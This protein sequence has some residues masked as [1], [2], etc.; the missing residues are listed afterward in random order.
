MALKQPG[1]L[2]VI[3]LTMLCAGCRQLSNQ[4][5]SQESELIIFAAA[6][7][8]DAFTEIARQFE[9]DHPG[10]KVIINFA[11]S[12]QLAHQ[13][14]QG[15]PADVFASANHRQMEA[16]IGFGRVNEEKVEIFAGNRLVIA[17]PSSN[18]ADIRT[19]AG[20]STPGLKLLLAAPEVPAGAYTLILLDN[21]ESD[22]A[23]GPAFRNDVLRNVVSY[24]ENVRAVLS[25]VMLGEA[26][27]GIVYMSDVAG[28]NEDEVG[29][30]EIPDHLNPLATYPIA[31]INNS[32]QPELGKVFIDFLLSSRGQRLISDYGFSAGVPSS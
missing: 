5:S 24:E 1:L 28:R 16:A 2:L 8:A 27:A 26:D 29:L 21:L 25:K 3:L 19:L 17:Y 6:S 7:L 13:L 11:G 20:L 32:P 10:V 9:V 31:T 12:Q 18:P 22:T 15:A 23:F 4:E 14:S 30:I